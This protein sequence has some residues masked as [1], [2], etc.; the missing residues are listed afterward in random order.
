MEA[1]GGVTSSVSGIVTSD[2]LVDNLCM[3]VDNEK[4]TSVILFYK[5]NKDAFLRE[6]GD[7][8]DRNND[9]VSILNVYC[10]K[11]VGDKT[12]KNFFAFFYIVRWHL[13]LI[14][15]C[16]VITNQDLELQGVYT[17]VYQVSAAV[18]DLFDSFE[19]EAGPSGK[20]P[21]EPP[22]SGSWTSWGWQFL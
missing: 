21:I 18:S 6:N 20:Q 17:R 9:V 5:C 1:D 19:K 11:L 7:I 8:C 14:Q 10:R 3:L 15:E 2:N 4:W 13:N 16:Y 12:G 22:S